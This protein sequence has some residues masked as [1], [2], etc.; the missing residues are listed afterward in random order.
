[1]HSA[2]MLSAGEGDDVRGCVAMHEEHA[3][4]VRQFAEAVAV[5]WAASTPARGCEPVATDTAGNATKGK[6]RVRRSGQEAP[7][8]QAALTFALLL[9]MATLG[10]EA[11]DRNPQLMSSV[12][13]VRTV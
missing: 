2:N 12:L 1:M 5:A 13:L 11:V 7:C 9:C 6:Q 4:F 8:V 10:G 3:C